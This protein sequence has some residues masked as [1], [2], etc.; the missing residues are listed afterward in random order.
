MTIFESEFCITNI[1]TE[2]SI[3]SVVWRAATADMT[4]KQFQEHLHTFAHCTE[5]YH[6]HGILV[7]AEDMGFVIPPAIQEWHDEYIVPRYSDAGVQKMAFI[8]PHSFAA[9][10]T[11]AQTFEEQTA[12]E[13]ISME[14]FDNEIAAREW[15]NN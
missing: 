6:P 13:L 7:L 14:F 1:D 15:L 8:L 4:A 5:Q 11:T 10:V 12:Q 2:R 3:L 9:Q